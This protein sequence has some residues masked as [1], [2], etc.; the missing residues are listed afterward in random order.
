MPGAMDNDL[1]SELNRLLSTPDH[2]IGAET[3]NRLIL[4]SL[5]SLDKRV[6]TIEQIA[7]AVKLI[8]WVGAAIGV[9]FIGLI[10]AVIT[11]Q[12]QIIFV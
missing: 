5:L 8:M 3:I 11:G 1:L 12:A 9:S 2:G 6:R 10:W 7:P 4:A